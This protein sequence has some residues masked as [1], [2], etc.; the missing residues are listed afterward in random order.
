MTEQGETIAQKY[1][2]LVTATYHLELLVAGVT[3]TTIEHRLTEAPPPPELLPTVDALARWSRDAYRELI[4]SPGFLDYFHEA[5]PIDALQQARIGSRP[6]RRAQGRSLDDLRAIPWVFGWTQSR[7]YLSGWYGVG[8]ALAELERTEP[9]SFARLGEWS[10]RWPFLRYVLTNVESSTASADVSIMRAYAGLVRGDE[11][12][13]VVGGRIVEELERTRAMLDRIH[14]APLTERRPRMWR[15][16]Q[17]RD[18]GLRALHAFQ[19]DVL[20]RWR[21]CLAAGDEPG[22]DALLPSVL[23]SVNAI[24]NGLRTTG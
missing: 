14:G 8:S 19:I 24:A 1:A 21:G 3:A 7:H 2:N 11:V 16:L 6:A 13:R 17:L 22:A 23:Q 9:A 15:T 4:A 5:T 20:R 10:A 12:R 18:G